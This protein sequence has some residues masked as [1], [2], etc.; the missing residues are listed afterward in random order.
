MA[1]TEITAKQLY[2]NRNTSDVFSRLVIMGVLRVLNQK[3]K[4]THVWED[5]EE[6]T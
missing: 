6:G 3:L 4:Y 1:K 5:T 2:E